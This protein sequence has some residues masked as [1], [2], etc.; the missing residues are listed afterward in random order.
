MVRT[1]KDGENGLT[2]FNITTNSEYVAATTPSGTL[3]DMGNFNAGQWVL[4]GYTVL[5]YVFIILTIV[6][7]AKDKIKLK[8]LFIIIILLQLMFTVTHMPTRLN[9]NF[10]ITPLGFARWLLYQDGS[11]VFTFFVPLG[12]IIYWC[13]RKMLMKEKPQPLT[14]YPPYST[15]YNM[16]PR[17]AANSL[18]FCIQP[19]SFR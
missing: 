11:Y 15:N 3:S 8:P 7:C 4:L 10:M 5:V 13:I 2:G 14:A 18:I 12:A 1:S 19:A 9:F 16:P 6:R 17:L